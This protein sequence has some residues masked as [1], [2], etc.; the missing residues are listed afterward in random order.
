[1]KSQKWKKCNFDI[2]LQY[3]FPVNCKTCKNYHPHQMFR[4]IAMCNWW[5][6]SPIW[7]NQP[8]EGA[9]VFWVGGFI[10]PVEL[11]YTILNSLLPF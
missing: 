5:Q 7:H 11:L 8:S 6:K 9:V 10:A 2:G 3:K 1:M 4:R